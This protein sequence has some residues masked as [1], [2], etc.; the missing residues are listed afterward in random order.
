MPDLRLSIELA[1]PL[2]LQEQVNLR[3]NCWRQVEAG[4]AWGQPAGQV[5]WRCVNWLQYLTIDNKVI[6]QSH[7]S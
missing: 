2:G 4:Q 1:G 3:V 5:W 7:I 6:I